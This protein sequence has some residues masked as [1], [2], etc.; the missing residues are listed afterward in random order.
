MTCKTA[1]NRE[2]AIAGVPR[3][4]GMP[5][6]SITGREECTVLRRAAQRPGASPSVIRRLIDLLIR[7]DAFDEAL[8]LIAKHAMLPDFHYV[9]SKVAALFG[10]GAPGDIPAARTSAEALE[11]LATSDG[12]RSA[13]L[14]Q[15]ARA[16]Q[17]IGRPERAL[18]FVE[19]AL[20]L[21]P[22]NASAL[23]RLATIR[24]EASEGAALLVRTGELR[25]QGVLHAQALA[26]Q[27]LALSAQGT[28]DEA[29]VLAGIP[30]WL[31]AQ[32]LA[33]PSPWNGLQDFHADLR[34]EL[35]ASPGL[36]FG[37]HGTASRHTMRVDEPVTASTPALQALLQHL[38][39]VLPG[40]LG[41]LGGGDHPLQ[42][43]RPDS[44]E[45]RLWCVITHGEGY[46]RWHMHPQ[47]W[48]S[49]GY[50]VAVPDSVA[51]ERGA[52]GCLE[53]GLPDHPVGSDA[54]LAFGRRI[55]R[56]RPGLLTLFPSHAYH[57]THPHGSDQPRIC[58]AFDLIPSPHAVQSYMPAPMANNVGRRD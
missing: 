56:P 5:L 25:A 14:V 54:A 22:A 35:L 32:D 11:Q 46:E 39:G 18:A 7:L 26:A 16:W 6:P 24:L 20:A 48:M 1:A 2:I 17:L 53:F 58:L 4:V 29:R 28:A 8:A 27:M 44:A 52:G 33:P 3:L 50:Y 9:D 10:R 47:G 40:L 13:A 30:D 41:R 23:R 15:Q 57:R 42:R 21:D 37:R 38:L 45:L 51:E 34:R 36:R 31:F 12:Q 49:G 19:A 43:A 55:V